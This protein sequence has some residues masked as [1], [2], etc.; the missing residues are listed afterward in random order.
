[1]INERTQKIIEGIEVLFNARV[2]PRDLIELINK[3]PQSDFAE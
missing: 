1:M 3:S 2:S